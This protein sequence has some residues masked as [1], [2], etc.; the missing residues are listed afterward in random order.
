MQASVG[1]VVGIGAVQ[2]QQKIEDEKRIDYNHRVI[3]D[4]SNDLWFRGKEVKEEETK[5]KSVPWTF[6]LSETGIPQN[7]HR[8]VNCDDLWVI[9]DVWS[10]EPRK[11]LA[12]LL[13]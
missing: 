1:Q 13:T 5:S 3:L 11:G 12:G 10:E 9:R 6:S 8:V 2:F 7:G 4:M